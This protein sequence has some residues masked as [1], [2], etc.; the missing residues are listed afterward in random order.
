[1]PAPT[2]KVVLTVSGNISK[3]NRGN[4]AVFDD[5]MLGALPRIHLETT[6][7][8]TDGVKRFDGFLMRDL[9]AYVGAD[10]GT[11][12]AIALNDYVIDIPMEDFSR[13]DVLV[14]TSMDGT[15]LLPSDKGPLWIVYPRDD[16]QELQDIRYDYRWVWQLIELDVR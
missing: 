16:H 12:T 9:L 14:A 7:V 2:G 4:L 11:V 5:D 1:M 3:T 15:R 8:V 10:G 13:F 6:T